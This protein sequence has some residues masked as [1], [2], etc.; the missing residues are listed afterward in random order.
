MQ[1][2]IN[3]RGAFLKKEKN[4]FLVRNDEKTF[5]VSADKVDSILITTAATITTDAIEFAVEKNIDIVFLNHFGD[6]YGRVWHSKLG[7]TTLIRRRQL[8]A[9]STD[10][11]FSL[12]RGWIAQK[13]ANQIDFVKDLKKNRPDQKDLL[14]P[15]I[16]KLDGFHDS[17]KA[18]KGSLDFKRG[19]IMG[20]EGMASQAYFDAISGIMPDQW[21]FKG[22]SR[23]PARDAF[24]CL[25]N[26]GYGV[27]Y[28]R[29]ER[30]CIIAGLDP[31]VGFLHTDNY[32]K[33]SFV[34][35]LIELFR[36]H[37]DRS[38][39]NL[40]SR[41]Q[42]SESFFD[43]V[44]GG[45][46]LNKEGKALLIGAVNEMFDREI[47]YRGRNVRIGNTIQMECHRIANTLIK[48]G[49]GP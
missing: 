5:E 2:V 7:S 4:C 16:Q 42:V 27:L 20:L 29:V 30:A 43:P 47:E 11:G 15:S 9:E 8:E 6:P 28:S 10:L 49:E 34:F 39:V 44:P 41:K 25:L 48:K 26:Y 14:E 24:N 45:L 1:L 18:M 37:I 32:N 23:D 19:S 35:D 3:T 17:L 12:A 33:R 36:I 13:I 22:R 40:F 38:V 46:Y 21:K 31:Y